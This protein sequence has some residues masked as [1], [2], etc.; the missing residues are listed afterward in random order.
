M[1]SFQ[2][3]VTRNCLRY[4]RI[5]PEESIR[6]S[7]AQRTGRVR[8]SLAAIFR[9]LLCVALMLPSSCC[10]DV[11]ILQ[12][13]VDGLEGTK[14][15][16]MQLELKYRYL[17]HQPPLRCVL[18]VTSR[19]LVIAGFRIL[20]LQSPFMC[21]SRKF[22][23]LRVSCQVVQDI[24]EVLRSVSQCLPTSAVRGSQQLL[25]LIRFGRLL[26]VRHPNRTDHE[27][28]SNNQFLPR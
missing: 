15:R 3:A 9:S 25:V 16:M 27:S 6:L 28:L 14:Q 24:K 7:L 4:R 20:C 8:G 23:G 26:A 1:D 11:Q 2:W 13:S 17:I 22:R 21:P 19:R 18:C 10:R 12:D 5:M